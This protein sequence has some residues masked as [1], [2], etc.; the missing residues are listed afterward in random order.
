MQKKIQ[1]ENKEET[2]RKSGGY[3]ERKVEKDQRIKKG[4][5]RRRK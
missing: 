2:K 3:K 1:R 5:E 4:K